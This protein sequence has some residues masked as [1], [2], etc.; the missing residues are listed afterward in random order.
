MHPFPRSQSY[1]PIYHH[2]N[3]HI[4]DRI[5]NR[6]A[7]WGLGLGFGLGMLKLTIQALF[8]AG[9]MESPAVLA[10]IGDFNFLYFSG[11]LFLICSVIIV[12]MSYTSARPDQEQIRGLTFSSLDRQVVRASWD[13]KDVIATTIILGLVA[14]MYVYFSFW[15]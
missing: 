14:T 13:R 15:I 4:N 6:G 7:V 11:V 12:G 9:K 5:N 1:S 3:S 2:I 10:A 8:G